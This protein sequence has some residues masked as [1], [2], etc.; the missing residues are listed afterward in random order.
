MR[1][2]ALTAS[3]T[4]LPSF[5]SGSVVAGSC[6]LK[7]DAPRDHVGDG[8]GRTLERNVLRLEACAGAQPLGAEMRRRPDA[9]GRVVQR[10]GLGLSGGDQIAERLVALGG[11][12]MITRVCWPSEATGMKS[13]TES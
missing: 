13:F 1:F 12:A 10:A 4:S 7:S 6:T 5:R 11:R 3:A 8:L 9:R 2:C